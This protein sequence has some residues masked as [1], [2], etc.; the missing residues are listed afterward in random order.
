MINISFIGY[1]NMAKA[2]AKGL[3]S[4]NAFLLQ[5][6]SPSLTESRDGALK[7][8][9]SNLKACQEAEVIILAV[10]P[11]QL[12]D[13]LAE[14]KP[15]LR[16]EQLLISVAAGIDL[17]TLGKY[18]RPSQAI[19]RCMPN[20]ASAIGEGMSALIGNAKVTESQKQ[21]ALRIFQSV[22]EVLWLDY[23]EQMHLVTAVSGS[24]PAYVYRIMEA[25]ILAAT[26]LGLPQTMA[27]K[28]CR[29]T[30]KGALALLDAS[31]NSIKSLRDAIT[32]PNG[33]TAA[34]LEVLGKEQVDRLLLKT[35]DAAQ[36]RSKQ[37]AEENQ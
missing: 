8:T 3:M 7:T 24:G 20:T 22:G 36:K 5:A 32:S 30:F 13:V 25:M 29:Q 34:A 15:A 2:I 27:E 17:N 11:Y 31:D 33:T 1:G 10:K 19:I 9:A 37:L 6:A 28:L 4:N 16:T 35:L 26:E 23:E 12:A 14:I 18:S 21:L